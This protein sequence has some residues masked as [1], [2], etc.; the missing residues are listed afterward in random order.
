[1]RRKSFELVLA[2]RKIEREGRHP[3]ADCAKSCSVAPQEADHV[4]PATVEKREG[5]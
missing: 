3:E 4:K 2:C 5:G 1:M